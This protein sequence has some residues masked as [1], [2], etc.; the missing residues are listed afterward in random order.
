MA[1]QFTIN[2]VPLDADSRK[3]LSPGEVAAL[4]RVR[5]TTVTKWARD[6]KLDSFR[7]PGGH[8]RVPRPAVMAFLNPG[9]PGRAS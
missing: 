8:L 6:G 4:F 9:T 1:R 3:P 5:A 7:T 2:G